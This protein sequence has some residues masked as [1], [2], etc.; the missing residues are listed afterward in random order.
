MIQTNCDGFTSKKESF[1]NIVKDENPDIIVINDTALKGT[2]KVKIPKYFSYTKNSEENK[3]GVATVVANYLKPNTVKVAEG[4][5]GDEYVITRFDNT[6]PAINLINIYGEQEGRSLVDGI[7]KRWLRLESDIEEIESRNEAVMIMGDMNRA[8]GN[9]E[10]GIKDIKDKISKEGKMIRDLINEKP[11][12]ILNNLDAAKDGPWTWT[13]RQNGRTQSCLDLVIASDCLLP[14]VTL[15]WVDRKRKFTPRRVLRSKKKLKT[16]YTDHFPIKV[17]LSGI[18]RRKEESKQD[19]TWNLGRPGGWELYEKL[20]NEAANKVITIAEEKDDDINAK[21]KKI[22]VIE[23]KIKFQAFGKS[24]PSS[25]KFTDCKKCKQCRLLRFNPGAQGSPDNSKTLSQTKHSKCISCKT[26]EEKD[27]ELLK[28]QSD[29]LE[30]AIN[31]IKESKLGRAGSIYKMKD[32][33]AGQKKAK[34]EATAVRD[35]RTG[36]L[37]VSKERIKEVTLEYVVN[38]LKGN[39]PEEEVKEM[40][41]MRRKI[42]LEKMNDKSGELCQIEK[43]D[44]ET[45]LMKFKSKSTKN[46]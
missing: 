10:L 25:K 9:G 34:Q 19:P 24:K 5:E 20:T 1:D 3:G 13:D 44:F 2:R 45:V 37:T 4:K 16:I 11:C 32:E 14:Y 36:E 39:V 35:P 26:Q 15:V 42:Q 33:I 17:E 27:E 6:V 41:D 29:K 21:M 22:E 23:K 43:D 18:P 40:V 7:E 30:N 38:N 46:L 28:R 8:I 31:K 12:T